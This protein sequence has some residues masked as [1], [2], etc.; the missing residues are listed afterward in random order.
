MEKKKILRS[1][2]QNKEEGDEEEGGDGVK[3][4]G[5]G[6]RGEGE[7]V[8]GEGWMGGERGGGRKLSIQLK[9]I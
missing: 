7:R 9:I 5:E 2:R 4:G 3:V 1:T 6:G 8:G